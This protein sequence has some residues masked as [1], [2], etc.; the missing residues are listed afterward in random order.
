MLFLGSVIATLNYRTVGYVVSDTCRHLTLLLLL[1][2]YAFLG[3]GLFYII[4]VPD[5]IIHNAKE[6]MRTNQRVELFTNHLTAIL[7]AECLT[8]TTFDE[9]VDLH[10]RCGE[11]IQFEI[12]QEF[13]E[14]LHVNFV[15]D[16]WQAL[17]YASTI[18]T[19]IGEFSSLSYAARLMHGRP[20]SVAKFLN[21]L[22]PRLNT[23][24]SH[25]RYSV[26]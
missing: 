20:F 12:Q 22:K 8:N 9:V 11:I 18:F 24:D 3:A 17:I 2:L 25:T 7:L 13:P 23:H 5:Q 14:I 16:Y 21:V 6:G 10:A 26:I 19:T 15:W 4:E 1:I